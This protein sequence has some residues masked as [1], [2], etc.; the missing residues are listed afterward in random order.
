MKYAQA[1]VRVEP[2]RY[3]DGSLSIILT[4]SNSN[5]PWAIATAYI[6]GANLEEDEVFIRNDVDNKGM[7]S[8]LVRQGI[9]EEGSDASEDCPKCKLTEAFI[10]FAKF[11]CDISGMSQQSTPNC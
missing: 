6:E 3:P 2:S 9:L 10:L 11:K 1:H 5:T 8:L 4:F 7:V